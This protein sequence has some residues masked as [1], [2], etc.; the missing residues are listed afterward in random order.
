M[1]VRRQGRTSFLEKAALLAPEKRYLTATNSSF[2]IEMMGVSRCLMQEECIDEK[3]EKIWSAP[4]ELLSTRAREIFWLQIQ[5]QTAFRPISPG[6]DH[7]LERS[8]STKLQSALGLTVTATQ[9]CA[10]TTVLHLV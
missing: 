4:E 8:I 9:W 10:I 2:A 1:C 6:M 5:A 7:L 3:L